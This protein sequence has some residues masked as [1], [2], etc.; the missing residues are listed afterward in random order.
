[1]TP[2]ATV[3]DSTDEEHWDL[4]NSTDLRKTTIF[5]PISRGFHFYDHFMKTEEKMSKSLEEG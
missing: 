1:M 3:L 2:V 5:P 4:L